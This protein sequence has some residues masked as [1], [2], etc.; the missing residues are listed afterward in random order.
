MTATADAPP[1]EA[2]TIG[3]L[4][5][6]WRRARDRRTAWESHW[7]DCYDVA[8]PQ[9]EVTFGGPAGGKRTDHLFDG[10]APDAVDQLAASLLAE[11]TPPW[12]RWFGLEGGPGLAEDERAAVAPLLEEAAE[13]VRLHFERSGFAVEMH[14]AFLDLVTVGTAALLFEESAPGEPSAF[15]FTAVPMAELV[16]EEGPRG[17]LDTTFRR[18]EMTLAALRD[19]FPGGTLP[20]AVLRRAEDDPDHRFAV[21]E[22]VLPDGEAYAY[23]ALLLEDGGPTGGP[24]ATLLAEGRFATTPFI[25]FRWL[26]APGEA[27]GR[28]PVMKA[29]P[30]IKT[31]NKVV[32]LILK[33]ASIS[34]TGIWQAE[35]DGVLNPAT[36]RLVPGA[37]IAK[38]AGSSGLTPLEAPGR[39]DVSQLVL[40]DLRT[41]IRHALLADRL[42]Q[43]EA[44]RMTATEV[45]ER[46]AEMAR[47]L[48]ATYGRLQ[49]ELLTP[50]VLRAVS[51]L[52]RRGEIASLRVDG[53]LV[54]LQY[55]SP[56]ARQQARQ[57]AQATLTWL[58]SVTA[59]GPEALATV[60]L[61]AAARSLA[62][63]LSVPPDL[64]RAPPPMPSAP[65]APMEPVALNEEATD[66]L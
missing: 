39:F 32:E 63:A 25:T 44:P 55:R 3:R 29:L 2:E 38:A 20:E 18:S 61:P 54:D 35:D 16:V 23:T 56:L 64:V 21:L 48:G 51:I 65:A 14:Q 19:R 24:G 15:R 60:D 6:R 59:L 66:G 27:Y 46:S 34:V 43:V 50:L 62:R 22:A 8:L 36:V 31:A 40:D 11:L 47:I 49:A 10:T 17:R 7:R 42:A 33:N 52:R 13:T 1:G 4:L 37:I 57:E 5:D 53:R 30:D 28:S 45:L 9:R 58:D 12:A 41:R 26:K